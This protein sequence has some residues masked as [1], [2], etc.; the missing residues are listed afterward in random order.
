M[1]AGNN[2]EASQDFSTYLTLHTT[3]LSNSTQL[4]ARLDYKEYNVTQASISLSG[5]V[6]GASGAVAC[7][8]TYYNDTTE[9]DIEMLTRDPS[10]QM[11]Y[12][13]QPTTDPLTDE[14]IGG[15]TFNRSLAHQNVSSWNVH[16]LDWVTGLSAW[17]VNGDLAAETNVN[18][19]GAAS[20]IIMNMWSNGGSFSGEMEI[21][22]EAWF[23]V[24]WVE[25]MFNTDDF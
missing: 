18:V 24:Q 5:R 23:D 7:F 22:E 17:Y 1:T 16:R 3:R 19:P 11:R 13:N 15:S 9:S 2:T 25:L 21:G 8:F 4:A 10:Q 14:D 20:M 12:S 6:R